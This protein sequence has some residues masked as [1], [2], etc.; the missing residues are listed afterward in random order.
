MTP[1]EGWDGGA[2]PMWPRPGHRPIDARLPTGAELTSPPPMD[3]ASL[4]DVTTRTW[5]AIY[6]VD[7]DEG[8]RLG[9]RAVRQVRARRTLRERAD[10][11]WRALMGDIERDLGG[12]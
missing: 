3:A 12:E 8:V 1:V 7:H 4:L 5:A 2:L 11:D 10:A 9:E 6:V